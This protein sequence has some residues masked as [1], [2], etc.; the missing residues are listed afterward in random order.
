VY[1]GNGTQVFQKTDAAISFV[2][3]L[4]MDIQQEPR[5]ISA[6]RLSKGVVIM[7]DDGK[8]ALY[9]AFLLRRTLP[10]AEQ[11]D[12]SGLAECRLAVSLHLRSLE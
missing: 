8:S 1:Q 2:H 11:L 3:H 9:S 4:V 5:V 6:D 7:F 10:Q 12:E